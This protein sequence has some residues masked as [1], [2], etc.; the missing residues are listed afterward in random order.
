MSRH[1]CAPQTYRLTHLLYSSHHHYAQSMRMYYSHSFIF[2]HMHTFISL[3]ICHTL[4]FKFLQYALCCSHELSS[5]G[6]PV[7]QWLSVQTSN[8]KVLGSTPDGNT[9][10]SFSCGTLNNAS[11]SFIHQAYLNLTIILLNLNARA[12]CKSCPFIHN[13]DK[14]RDPSHALK[15]LTV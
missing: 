13:I 1:Q 9:R 4:I 11:F 2:H 6:S 3:R 14:F 15:S 8:R 10:I 12:R 7:S 5:H